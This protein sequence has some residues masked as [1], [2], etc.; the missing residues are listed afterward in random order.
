[1]SNKNQQLS[2]FKKNNKQRRETIAKKM[3]YPTAAAYM[4]TLIA[5]VITSAPVKKTKKVKKKI[6]IHIVDILDVSGSMA[7]QNKIGFAVKGIKS[8]VEDLKGS[9][10]ANYTHTLV[11]FSGWNDIKTEY[12][13][14]PIKDA[15]V[16]N[17]STRGWTALSD[18]LGNT[19]QSLMTLANGKDKYLI[20]I[21]TDGGEN[22]SRVWNHQKVAKMIKEAEKKGFTITFVG[23]AQ[24]VRLATQLYSID[25]SNTLVHE[26]TAD[27]VNDSF[28]V[29]NAA[30]MSYA[31]GASAGRA[32][33][34]GFYKKM[35]KL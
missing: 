19:I 25:D 9:D 34:K 7:N 30:T 14:K 6:T 18:A 31:A 32:V 28:I 5:T 23:T 8:G 10:I 16:P 1:M 21:F 13:Q 24:D 17:L 27:S 2:D 20:K 35:G 22:D 11:H 4:Q 29:S 33:T 3:G 12:S 15:V 26:N